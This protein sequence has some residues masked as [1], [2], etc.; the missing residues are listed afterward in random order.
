MRKNVK[1]AVEMFHQ[2]NNEVET[3]IT[4]IGAHRDNRIIRNW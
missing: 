1:E 4:Y 3:F 2:S